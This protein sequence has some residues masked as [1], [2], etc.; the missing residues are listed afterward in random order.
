[1]SKIAPLKILFLVTDSKKTDYA[2]EILL[3]MGVA[4]MWTFLCRGVSSSGLMDILGLDNPEKTVF[5]A[6]VS[7]KKAT[8]TLGALCR[9]L[10]LYKPKQGIAFTVPLGAISRETLNFFLGEND[11]L[12]MELSKEKD[13]KEET[14]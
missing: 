12:E 9:N 10:E 2:R 4:N 13:L 6:A 1:M 8:Q 3:N 5:I 11:E 14:K 7:S